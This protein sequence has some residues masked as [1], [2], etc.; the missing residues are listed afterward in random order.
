[1][2]GI[3]T[4]CVSLEGRG[5]L[6]D[7]EIFGRPNKGQLLEPCFAALW[8]K[9]E[10]AEPQA[11]L[12]QARRLS[13]YVGEG[14]QFWSYGHGRMFAFMDGLPCFEQAVFRHAFPFAHIELQ[15]PRC[16][17][18]V[19]LEAFSP[20][21]PLDERSSG[22][23]VASLTY[24]LRNA[25]D[26]QVEAVVVMSMANPVGLPFPV[27]EAKEKA[28]NRF[29]SGSHCRG[30]MFSNDRF[31]PQDEGFGTVALVTDRQEV[32]VSERWQQG[33]WWDPVQDF[34]NRFRETGGL[35]SR[36][37]DEPG[38]RRAASLGLS[39]TLEPG[40]EVEMPLLVAWC[41][42]NAVKQW[43]DEQQAKG[44]TWTRW[45]ATQWPTAWEAATEFFARK[46]ELRARSMEFSRALYSSTLP[47]EVVE[48]VAATA[49]T[50]R[51][52]TCDRLEDG[53]FWAWEGCSANAG[54]CEGSCSHVWNYALTHVFL[55]PKLQESMLSS[56]LRYGSLCGPQGAKGA[57]NFRIPLPL[58]S[59]SPLSNAASDGQ[60]GLLVQLYRHWKQT[61]DER[62]LADHWPLAKLAMKYAW[63]QWDRDQD[64]LVDGDMH[65]TYDINFQGPNPL[66]QFFYLGALRACTEIAEHLGEDSSR[67]QELFRAGSALAEE[68]LWN[69]KWFVQTTDCLAPDA[70]KYQQGVGCLSDQLFGQL[71]AHVA[72]LGYLADPD[73]VAQ[74]LDSVFQHNFLDPLDDHENLQRVYAVGD[75]SGLILCSWPEGGRPEFPFPYSDEVWTGIEYQV[76]SALAF[77]GR[78]DESLRIARAARAR[79][80]GRRR[81]PFNEFECGSHYARALASYGLLLALSG[82]TWDATTG[83]W[84]VK[85]RFNSDQPF[86]CLYCTP[87]GWGI[88]HSAEGSAWLE[89]LGGPPAG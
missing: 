3:G 14:S 15:H 11:R 18:E 40:E 25:S 76:A 22:L 31:G 65:N 71:T 30:V 2:G 86:R 44:A 70:P 61:G 59:P 7:W 19:S 85:P 58:G 79:H 88:A 83:E 69:G 32:M 4:G 28:R 72:G 35:A 50:L 80:D 84:S 24:R 63:V 57:L 77:E 52:P 47:E 37:P 38:P 42:P 23:P 34:W 89:Q 67:Y 54:C 66:T 6:R 87:Q 73:L 43:G 27:E 53:T 75:E 78:V 39:A 60:L 17:L 10:G 68:K 5:T 36:G 1:M 26:S 12:L 21:I 33:A 48:S 13:G 9:E 51:S 41:F 64:G 62:Y 29:Q 46:E 45:Y 16:P 81:N 82:F 74:A 49:T 56:H 20:F 8:V 55:F